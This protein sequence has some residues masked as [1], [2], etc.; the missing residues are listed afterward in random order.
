MD[1]LNLDQQVQEPMT[2]ETPEADT[3]IVT[4]TAQRRKRRKSKKQIFKEKYLPFIILG[5]SGLLCLSFIFGSA[6]MG[7]ARKSEKAKQERITQ[8]LHGRRV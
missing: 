7:R 5:V 8:L 4:P 1:E 2:P 3:P 6:S